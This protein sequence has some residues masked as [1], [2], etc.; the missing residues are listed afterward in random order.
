MQEK[1]SADEGIGQEIC[2]AIPKLLIEEQV[3]TVI[4]GKMNLRGIVYHI[5]DAPTR[6]H[7][8]TSVKRGDTWYT[9]NDSIITVDCHPANKYD[10]IPYLLIYEKDPESE[11]L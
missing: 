10:L 4:L 11:T 5:G 2:K 8:V 3:N 7:Y 1:N 6:G 9:C